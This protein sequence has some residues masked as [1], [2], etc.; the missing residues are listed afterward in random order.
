MSY[1]DGD[2]GDD[3]AMD[4]ERVAA[5]EAIDELEAS[6]KAGGAIAR[7]LLDAKRSSDAARAALVTVDPTDSRAIM[8]LQWLVSRFDALMYWINDVK[9]AAEEA[10]EDFTESDLALVRALIKGEPDIKDA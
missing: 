8:R 2:V 3:V 4:A 10:V 5:I 6:I 7:L 1:L 9:E